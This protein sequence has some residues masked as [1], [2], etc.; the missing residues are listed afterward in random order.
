MDTVSTT[1]GGQVIGLTLWAGKVAQ[2]DLHTFAAQSGTPELVA[3][4]S[5]DNGIDWIGVNGNPMTDTSQLDETAMDSEYSHGVAPGSHL[6]FW[7]APCSYDAQGN[8]GGDST[9]LANAID[10]AAKDPAVHVVSNS[11]GFRNITAADARSSLVTTIDTSLQRGVAG[12]TTF[13]FATGDNGANSGCV[14]KQSP[15]CP[16]WYPASSRYAVAVGGTTLNTNSD[17]TYQS[18]SAWS[19][20]GGGCA[21]YFARPSWQTNVTAT[22]NGSTCTGRATPDVAA[23][24]DPTTGA[25]VYYQ[26]K[27]QAFGGT[28]LATPLW[29]GM[30]AD[31]DFSLGSDGFFLASFTGPELYKMEADPNAAPYVFHDMTTGNNGYSAGPGWDEATGLGSPDA[32]QLYLQLES[33]YDAPISNFAGTGGPG[34]SGDGGQATQALLNRPYGV[35]TSRDGTVYISD[36]ACNTV[37]RVNTGGNIVNV[38]GT[39]TPG[40]GSYSGDGGYASSA[41][42]N[43]PMGVAVYNNNNLYIV[44]TGNDVVREVTNG[45]IRTIAGTGTGGY[46][47]DGQATTH[48][49]S[50]PTGVAVDPST[51]LVYI[52]DAGNNLIRSIDSSGNMNTVAG[53]PR[54]AGFSGDGGPAPGAQLNDPEGVAV[55]LGNVYIADKGNNRI[56]IVERGNIATYAGTGVQGDTIDA[57]GLATNA[58]LDGPNS[59]TVDSFGNVYFTE[60]TGNRVREI[61]TIGP[62]IYDI[63]GTGGNCDIA[64]TGGPASQAHLCSPW[65]IAFDKGQSQLFIADQGNACVMRMVIAH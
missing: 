12:G 36:A 29:A 24:G 17:F 44:D 65:G 10:L 15:P 50:R 30:T 5:G 13:Y 3:G 28:S 20:S 49:L 31:I 48:Q 8:C 57:S 63:A 59:L 35:A 47:G 19:G 43:R 37:R 22:D 7:L 38:A 60:D 32:Y 61:D 33:Y 45:I 54:V 4:Q 1:A 40:V 56:R 2:P 26:G 53:T 39:G 52:A 27:D 11:W 25:I 58:Q 18:E 64:G 42:L 55:L 62:Y 46:N 9:G 16:P 51:G 6:K 21:T 23:A 41:H 34:C 14:D